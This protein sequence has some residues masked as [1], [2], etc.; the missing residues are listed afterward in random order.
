MKYF[1]TGMVTSSIAHFVFGWSFGDW[2]WWSVLL[3][4][5]GAVEVAKFVNGIELR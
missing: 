1:I 4:T 5:I 2:E 3:G